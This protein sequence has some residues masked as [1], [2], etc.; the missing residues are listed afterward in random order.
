MSDDKAAQYL[1]ALVAHP[2]PSIITWH[3]YDRVWESCEGWGRYVFPGMSK[4]CAF[5]CSILGSFS[6]QNLLQFTTQRPVHLHH[7]SSSECVRKC[8]QGML[9]IIVLLKTEGRTELWRN[10]QEKSMCDS[11]TIVPSIWIRGKTPSW[12]KHSHTLTPSP[13]TITLPPSHTWLDSL[14]LSKNRDL[15]RWRT[16]IRPSYRTL[17]TWTRSTVHSPITEP[18]S[19]HES[20]PTL[21]VPCGSRW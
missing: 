13:H 14:Y 9:R 5:L 2:F 8:T 21:C 3:L 15:P 10:K 7:L 1:D 16:W 18:S 20:L 17:E 4:K 12:W 6:F 11:L 19:W